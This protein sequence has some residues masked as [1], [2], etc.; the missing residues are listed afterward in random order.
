MKVIF[1]ADTDFAN[2]MTS[3]SKCLNDHSSY[4]TST[5]ICN[6]PHL[7]N[8]SIK[9]DY[10]IRKNYTPFKKNKIKNYFE[11]CDIIVMAVEHGDNGEYN[12]FKNVKEWIGF[13]IENSNKRLFTRHPGSLYRE[14]S[15]YYNNHKQRNR[16]EKHLYSQDLYRLSPQKSN[17]FI[18]RPT[19]YFEYDRDVIISKFIHKIRDK[20]RLITHS[21]SNKS[22]KGSETIKE[23]INSLDLT[24]F[25]T[26]YIETFGLSHE[27]ASKVKDQSLFYID[28]FHSSI[29]GFGVSSIEAISKGCFSFSTINNLDTPGPVISLGVHH[30]QFKDCIKKYLTMSDN[31]LILQANKVLDLIELEYTPKAVC[32]RLEKLFK[33]V[34]NNA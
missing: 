23:I 6:T 12:L 4:V 33:I 7:F 3:W 9:H 28:Q 27:E 15:D 11:E 30:N 14:H 5:V 26:S 8:Y 18:M 29:G 19:T 22:K 24:S 13:D 20:K 34:E 2:T 1:L 16:I 32:N 25:N 10:N 21:P 31:Q 17:D